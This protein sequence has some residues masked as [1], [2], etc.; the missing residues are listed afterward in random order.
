MK[1][2]L[3]S[4]ALILLFFNGFGALYGG[5]NLIYHPSGESLYMNTALLANSP[6]QNYLI[7]GIIL[8]VTNGVFSLLVFTAVILNYK[9]HAWL[10]IGQGIILVAWM[11]IQLY[12]IPEFNYLQLL[13]SF[14]GIFLI[15]LGLL[16]L[17]IESRVSS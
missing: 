9:N 15:I 16:L 14:G 11:I 17:K 3:K 4:F 6:F 8:F 1:I 2:L 5:L 10:I 12:Y 13:Y 7:P